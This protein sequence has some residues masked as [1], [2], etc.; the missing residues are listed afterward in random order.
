[1]PFSLKRATLF[2]PLWNL[3]KGKTYA[4]YPYHRITVVYYY[5]TTKYPCQAFI[6][7]KIW[8]N[9]GKLFQLFILF[10]FKICFFDSL[11]KVWNKK[12]K[13]WKN[14]RFGVIFSEIYYQVQHLAKTAVSPFE[15]RL[16]LQCVALDSIFHWKERQNGGFSTAFPFY[17]KPF[18]I[19]QKNR[20]KK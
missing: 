20:F 3:N 5:I 7:K 13:R 18:L 16:F 2:H 9:K 1:M 6:L 17:F 8:K 14:H 4:F 15:I 19:Y 10:I 12:E 11:K